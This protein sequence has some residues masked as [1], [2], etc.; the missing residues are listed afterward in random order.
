MKDL[1][2]ILERRFMLAVPA[3]LLLGAALPAHATSFSSDAYYVGVEDHPTS[4]QGAGD[5]DYND[6]VFTLSGSG[7]KL[8]SNGTLSNPTTPNNNGV[9]FWDNLS[10]DGAGKNFGNCLYTAATNACTGG[11]PINPSA[12]Y[13]SNGGGFVGFDFSGATD[14]VTLTINAAIHA[15]SDTLFWCTSAANCHAISSGGAFAPGSGDFYFKLLDSTG[16]DHT[17][18]SGN[19]NFAVALNPTQATPEPLT[20]AL[21]GSGLLGLLFLRRR[22]T[23]SN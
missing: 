12:E 5:K 8:N 11:A 20:L 16:T 15:D 6:I 3:V 14:T 18:T 17:Y 19:S 2:A 13:L 23:G 22:R 9:P 10:S 7:L 1:R 4:G 21:T